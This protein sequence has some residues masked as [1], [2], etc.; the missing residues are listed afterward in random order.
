MK[1]LLSL[2]TFVAA[3]AA[4]AAPAE[5]RSCASA[6][7]EAV[8]Y[9]PSAD[10]RLGATGAIVITVTTAPS[11]AVKLVNQNET[12]VTHDIVILSQLAPGSLFADPVIDRHRMTADQLLA[13]FEAMVEQLD[14]KPDQWRFVLHDDLYFGKQVITDTSWG[15]E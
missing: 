15:K 10:N 8:T 6:T 11:C 14:D 4:A 13:M 2:V 5:A 7:V 12:T 9:N 3:L 1:P